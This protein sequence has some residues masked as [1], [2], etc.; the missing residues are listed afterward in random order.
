[1]PGISIVVSADPCTHHTSVTVFGMPIQSIYMD[2]DGKSFETNFYMPHCKE[3]SNN[4]YYGWICYID[5]VCLIHEIAAWREAL[6]AMDK[7]ESVV[8]RYAEGD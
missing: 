5:L 4:V 1:M 6:A 8:K 2:C 3:F 7:W